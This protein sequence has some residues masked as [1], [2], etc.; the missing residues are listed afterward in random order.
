MHKL[1]KTHKKTQNKHKNG[2]QENSLE[3]LLRF[4][5]AAATQHVPVNGRLIAS[6]QTK[7]WVS[8]RLL[9]V[10]EPQYQS[11]RVRRRQRG[12]KDGRSSASAGEWAVTREGREKGSE[13]GTH[14]QEGREAQAVVAHSKVVRFGPDDF[15]D[16][17]VELGL[18]PLLVGGARTHITN[19]NSLLWPASWGIFKTW[20]DHIMEQTQRRIKFDVGLRV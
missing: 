20:S 8:V 9:L 16:V 10:R 5:R 18:F 7:Q 15:D 1:K 19:Q 4:W 11:G 17:L 3:L 13:A 12:R 2:K 14:P 6:T